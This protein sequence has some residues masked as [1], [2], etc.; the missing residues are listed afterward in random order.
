[1]K[2]AGKQNVANTPRVGEKIDAALATV[3]LGMLC[4]RPLIPETYA[5][6]EVAFLAGLDTAGPTPSTT[7][8]LDLL[9]LLL[10]GGLLLRIGLRRVAT[11]A[12]IGWALLLLASVVSTLAADNG[13]VARLAAATPVAVVLAALALIAWARRQPAGRAVVLAAVLATGVTTAYQC[14]QQYYVELP[15]MRQMW[16]EEQKPA[17]L[18]Q[19]YAPDDPLLVNF[20]RRAASGEA[21]GFLAHPNITGSVLAVAS[22]VAFGAAL[23]G[24]W[25][26]R[27][28]TPPAD[29]SPPAGASAVL[30][31][32]IAVLL[33]YA[34]TLTGSIGAMVAA[35]A[36]LAVVLLAFALRGWIVKRPAVAVGLLLG[37]Y[38]LGGA[39]VAGYGIA[40]GTLPHPSLAFRWFYWTAAVEGY[41]EAPLT[42]LGREN[43][44]AA[45]MRLKP[46]E[47]T[48]EVRNAHNLWLSLLSEYGPLGLLAGVGLIAAALYAGFRGLQH[49]PPDAAPAFP[50]QV[51]PLAG[52]TAAVLALTHMVASG[53]YAQG[54]AYLLIWAID[55][56]GLWTLALLLSLWLLG[57]VLSAGRIAVLAG[58]VAAIVVALLHSFLSFALLTPGGLVVFGLCCVAAAGWPVTTATPPRSLPRGW[59]IAGGAVLVL[60]LGVQ[61]LTVR[62]AVESDA[63]AARMT[64]LLSASQPRADRIVGQALDMLTNH[65]GDPA[66]AGRGLQVLTRLGRDPLIPVQQRL[67]WLQAARPHLDNY[68]AL[69][70]HDHGTH[71]RVAQFHDVLA[72]A[73]DAAGDARAA[74]KQ[75]RAAA[76][77]WDLAVEHYP[78]YAR[79]HLAAGEAWVAVWQ[80]TGEEAAAAQA[81]EHLA[82]VE[83]IEA[84][85][86]PNEASRLGRKE[87]ERLLRAEEALAGV[88]SDEATERRSDGG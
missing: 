14:L 4:A 66:V 33:L 5:R 19:G 62:A 35:V 61:G 53:A 43:F 48:E 44:G 67:A 86:G 2:G 37:V 40:R 69:A 26:L 20:E 18:Q 50:G 63:Q 73:L 15:N 32:A 84:L 77:C 76:E 41:T 72:A 42:G 27:R 16:Q 74:R 75:R 78:T 31:A 22:A 80:D 51:W 60:L 85:R 47:S 82:A 13:Y 59:Q 39:G 23:A 12:W 21:H 58:V 10:A 28:K 3:L 29:R 17:L 45:Y 87:R 56:A 54:G 30:F 79:T 49:A 65:A 7:A 68:I 24:V 36:G 55:V 8:I 11:P 81:R 88:D 25:L 52:G 6:V 83:A 38:A 34:L 1:M 71:R 64:A 57:G 70:P 46:A 9:A